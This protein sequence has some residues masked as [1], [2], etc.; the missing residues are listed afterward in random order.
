VISL[1]KYLEME[2]HESAATKVDPAELL[3][4]LLECYRSA[5]LAMGKS[6]AQV[7]LAVGQDLQQNLNALESRL[8]GEVTPSLVKETDK[9]VTEQLQLWGEQSAAHS[10]AETAEVKELL[11][12][13]AQTAASVGERD[14]SYTQSLHQF[15]T[16]LRAIANLDD[17]SHIRASLVRQATELKTYVAK[18]EQ[19]SQTLVTQLKTDISTYETKLKEAEELASRDPLTGLPNRRNIEERIATRMAAGQG[20]CVVVVDVNQLKKVNDVHGHL[21]GDH[22]LQQFAQELRSSLRS[23]DLVGR[24]GGD[25]FI[26]VVAGDAAGAEAQIERMQKW[27]FGEYTLR[28]GKGSGE[29][30]VSVNAAAGLA[31]WKPGETAKSLIERADAAMYAQKALLKKHPS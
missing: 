26:A 30:K 8:A 20:L 10:E 12:V 11:I 28:P 14:Q 16:R 29:V 23:T 25:E 6:G 18:M 2:I 22:L 9:R 13:L 21:A 7:C 15:T 31:E 24:W 5:L 19:E 4:A 3:A 17:L 27:V 1:K